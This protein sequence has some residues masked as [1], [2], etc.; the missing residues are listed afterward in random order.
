V[1]VKVLKPW[2]WFWGL[3]A[4]FIS[5]G[6]VSLSSGPTAALFAPESINIKTSAGFHNLMWLMLITFIQAGMG[7]AMLYLAQRPVP[8]IRENGDT[9]VFLKE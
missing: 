6:A 4:G 7:G 2:T 1:S 8:E 5:G 9:K 3:L